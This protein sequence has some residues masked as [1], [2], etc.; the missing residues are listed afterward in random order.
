MISSLLQLAE[1]GVNIAKSVLYIAIAT[2][3]VA[4]DVVYNDWLAV[5]TAQ[6]V[7]KAAEVLL[8][9]SRHLLDVGKVS[10]DVAIVIADK[11]RYLSKNLI[12][13]FADQLSNILKQ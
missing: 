12:V 9:E 5:Y 11:S 13:I 7:L 2:W 3:D 8:A 10:T 1:Q 4:K 6:G